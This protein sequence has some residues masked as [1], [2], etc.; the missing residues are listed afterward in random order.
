[1]FL[2]YDTS[3]NTNEMFLFFQVGTCHDLFAKDKS[4]SAVGLVSRAVDKVLVISSRALS[5]PFVVGAS[6]HNLFTTRRCGHC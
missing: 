2:K 4:Q 1:M 5:S 3:L 6:A